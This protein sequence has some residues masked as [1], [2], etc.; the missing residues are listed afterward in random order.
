MMSSL[1]VIDIETAGVPWESMSEEE[2]AY[3]LKNCKT[4]EEIQAEKDKTG[5]YPLTGQVVSVALY[6]P[7]T[8]HGQV[9][10]LESGNA[11]TISSADSDGFTYHVH[12][13]KSMI[14]SFWTLVRS[15]DTVVTFNG[16]NFDIPFLL[17]RSMVHGLKPSRNLMP[18]RFQLRDHLDL[19]EILTFFGSTRRF[20]LDFY[21]RRLGIPSPK[22]SV[23]G[24]QV[25]MLFAAGDL[26]SIAR[27]NKQDVIATA[28][29]FRM[30]QSVY[31]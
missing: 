20:S 31:L 12:D 25:P 13:E 28:Q 30:V 5:L 6:N 1:V 24:E 14:S 21:C 2:Q 26:M 10:V 23:S 18:A 11:E 7:D 9:L 22:T 27:Y 19:M 15:F 16:R 17:F 8:G 4:E 29:L 3:L